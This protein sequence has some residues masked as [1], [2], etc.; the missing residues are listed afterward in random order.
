MGNRTRTLNTRKSKREA[1][2]EAAARTKSVDVTKA[3][4]ALVLI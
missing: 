3:G 4:V 1:E 2:R